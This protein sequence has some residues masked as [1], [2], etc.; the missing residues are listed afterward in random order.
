MHV[1]FLPR[2]VKG[3]A[4]IPG[5]SSGFYVGDLFYT[6]W[7][8]RWHTGRLSG[9]LTSAKTGGQSSLTIDILRNS[10]IVGLVSPDLDS[11]YHREDE[12]LTL[13]PY[14]T[15]PPPPSPKQWGGLSMQIDK[16]HPW[17]LFG[18]GY[19]ESG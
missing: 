6:A 8:T 4:E 5:S 15:N 13:T 3:T 2:V 19:E 11:P 7:Q 1:N 9:T 14:I 18:P 17:F 12:F 16:S 10:A